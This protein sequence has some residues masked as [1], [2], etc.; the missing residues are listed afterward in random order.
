MEQMDVQN[1][2]EVSHL[3]KKYKDFALKDV[4]FNFPK[5]SIMGF[6]GQNGAGKTTTIRSML[7]FMP[8]DSGEIK[9]LGYDY[10]KEEL[11]AKEDI[12]VVFDEIGF[13]K[14]MTP[15]QI[16]VMLRYIYKNWDETQY[17]KYLNSFGLPKN[18]KIE[19]FSRGMQMKLQIATAL[20][21]HARL[22][23][24]DEPTSG[25]DPI[26]RNEILDIFLEF[27]QDEDHSILLSSHITSDLERIADYITFIDKGR[28]LLSD[29]RINI[30]EKHGIVKGSAEEIA[31]LPKENIVGIRHSQFGSEAL[32]NDKGYIRNN[33]SNVLVEDTNLEEIMVFYVLGKGKSV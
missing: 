32:V 33:F 4:T 20:S 18:K 6:V 16:N 5:G 13:H 9:L 28:I 21:H 12:G 26:V 11:L 24:M 3:N 8:I 31:T 14:N 23:I 30:L 29:E 10:K 1:A 19:K 25:L 22:L 17:F 2:I 27:V 7:H 15:K